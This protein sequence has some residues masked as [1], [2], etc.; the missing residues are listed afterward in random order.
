MSHKSII[1]YHKPSSKHQST[2]S[3]S[4]STLQHYA[5]PWLSTPTRPGGWHQRFLPCHLGFKG[6]K[7]LINKKPKNNQSLGRII[8][9]QR[10]DGDV[11]DNWIIKIPN[12]EEPTMCLVMA[13]RCSSPIISC[14]LRKSM[15]HIHP[16]PAKRPQTKNS[17]VAA[18]D[19]WHMVVN[20]S[21]CDC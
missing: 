12:L 9:N 5:A 8:K 21:T 17:T 14:L 20:M 13:K 19:F 1:Q 10:C 11:K 2:H 15:L 7:M 3:S 6:G 18:S 4:G 16:I